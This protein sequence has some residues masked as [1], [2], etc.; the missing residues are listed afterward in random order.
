MALEAFEH[1]E[2]GYC[3]AQVCANGHVITTTADLGPPLK[4]RCAKCGADTFVKCP[5]C[6]ETIQ[7]AWPPDDS[8]LVTGPP[9]KFASYCPGCGA[10]YPW[11]A[12]KVAAAR[13][14]AQEFDGLSRE[15]REQLAESVEELARDTPQ[16]DVA[17]VRVKRIIGKIGGAAREVLVSALVKVATAE[18]K[19]K[20]GLPLT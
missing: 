14:V 16:Q 5:K 10:A 1:R 8:G 18:A 9:F 20:L 17:V 13:L 7:G 2:D 6:G 3:V 15:E 11:Q 12:R 19:A 4:P